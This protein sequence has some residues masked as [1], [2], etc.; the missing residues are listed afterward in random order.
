MSVRDERQPWE[1]QESDTDT[2][3]AVLCIYRD[4]GAG[5]SLQKAADVHYGKKAANVRRLEEWSSQSEWVA[6]CQAYDEHMATLRLKRLETAQTEVIDN[7]LS[8][9]L[10]F[11]D[12][13]N[14]RIAAYQDA[15]FAGSLDDIRSLQELMRKSDDMGRRAV[16][17]PDKISESN[18]HAT[19]DM[20]FVL[21]FSDDSDD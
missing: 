13:I 1:R 21:T 9:Y 17:L 8:D 2:S 19:G 6:R 7:A 15:K 11:R 20:S 5:R 4:M 12:I 18:V 10:F 16:G 14:K 3:Y